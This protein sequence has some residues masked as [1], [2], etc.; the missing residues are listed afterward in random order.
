MAERTLNL[1]NKSRPR[2]AKLRPID[3]VFIIVMLAIPVVHWFIFWLYV[4][5]N[6]IL[7][8]FQVPT[9]EWSMASIEQVIRDL[10]MPENSEL[11]TSV[12]NTVIYFIKDVL[13]L[14]IQLLVAYFLYKK[15]NGWRFFQI[16][17]YLP[18]IVSG[19][20]M[21]NMFIRLIR[22]DGPLGIILGNLG[23]DPIPRFLTNSDYA[24]KTILFYTIWMGFGGQ[25]LL[26]GGALAR[27]PLE[28]IES[29]RL[30]GITTPKE[31][32]YIIFPLVWGTMSTIL[33]L[34]MTQIFAMNGAIL[35]FDPAGTFKT[36]TIGFWIFNKVRIGG[37]A[38]YN[39]VAAAGLL[40]TLV[41]VPIILFL[42]WLIEKIPTV[43]Y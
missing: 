13:M 23:I 35:L 28:L 41:G 7:M 2:R 38:A 39:Q 12:I 20:A 5:L 3:K 16:V 15:V 14:P 43:E 24:T 10:S 1:S 6:S 31:F 27:I 25:M 37:A 4:N 33:I 17:F 30:D 21:A 29:A 32:I 22:F 26:F 8:A 42:K 36:S 11:L 40:F 18:T 19:V 34:V 9:G